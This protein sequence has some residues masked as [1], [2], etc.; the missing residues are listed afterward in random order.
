MPKVWYWQYASTALVGLYLITSIYRYFFQNSKSKNRILKP[1]NFK[2]FKLSNLNTLNILLP[3]TLLTYLL[4]ALFSPYVSQ[5]TEDSYRSPLY[6]FLGLMDKQQIAMVGNQFRDQGIITFALLTLLAYIIYKC[7][8][9]RNILIAFN[10]LILSSLIQACI[11]SY[12]FLSLFKAD[13]EL[14]QSGTRVFGSFGQ[15]NF[16]SGFLLIGFSLCLGLA[17]KYKNQSRKITI[18]YIIAAFFLSS[19][20][21]LSYSI[22]AIIL[23]I[24]T[25]L[26]YIFL[27]WRSW[28]YEKIVKMFTILGIIAFYPIIKIMMEYHTGFEQR[29]FFWNATIDNYILHPLQ[30]KAPITNILFGTGFDTIGLEFKSI[31]VFTDLYVDRAHNFFLDILAANGIIG[32]IPLI[33]VIFVLIRSIKGSSIEFK[34][35]L[36]ALLIWLARSSVHTS[37]IVN[38][39]E[40]FVLVAVCLKLRVTRSSITR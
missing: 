9:K 6:K 38:L 19:S 27:L 14:L 37:S 10:A 18:G 4:P 21:I 29:A 2:A 7:I 28:Y 1:L 40:F 3:L 26:I 36:T 12:Q 5:I 15:T 25:I 22:W 8:N 39:V 23:I 30:G 32:L 31:G 17:I 34:I 35:A 33:I 11:G 20:I 16:Y 24:F 13:E